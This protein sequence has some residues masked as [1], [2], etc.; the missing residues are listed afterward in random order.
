[1]NTEELSQYIE[2]L[3]DIILKTIIKTRE[4]KKIS[5]TA[6]AKLLGVTVTNYAQMELGNIRI[7]MKRML[8][9]MKFLNIDYPFV[10]TAPTSVSEEMTKQSE[11]GGE[12]EKKM[13]ENIIKIFSEIIQTNRQILESNSEI[14]ESNNEMKDML[15]NLLSKNL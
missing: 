9:I 7:D 6:I 3:D 2:N 14:L 10:S 11:R 1:M 5:K 12:T 4:D 13:D 15:N 8:A